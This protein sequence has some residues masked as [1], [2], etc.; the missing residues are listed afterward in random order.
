VKLIISLR[1]FSQEKVII[2][3][4]LNEEL[5]LKVEEFMEEVR[6]F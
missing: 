5:I 2:N 3:Y 4:I 6:S 1:F